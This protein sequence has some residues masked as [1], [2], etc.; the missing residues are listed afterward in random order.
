MHMFLFMQCMRRMYIYNMHWNPSMF[1]I[2]GPETNTL[3]EGRIQ[4][5]QWSCWVLG[6]LKDAICFLSKDPG[7][8][9]F[10]HQ[11]PLSAGFHHSLEVLFKLIS[12][13]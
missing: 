8:P 1:S 11:C 4:P 3:K 6:T 9:S 2:L 13:E 5:K 12:A 10:S 7:C